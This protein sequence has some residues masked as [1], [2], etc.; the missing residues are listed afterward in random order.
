MRDRQASMLSVGDMPVNRE[1]L[2]AVA[3]AVAAVLVLHRPHATSCCGEI[4]RLPDR[5]AG[6]GRR[7]GRLA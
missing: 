5:H 7:A 3:R 4:S 6:G 1:L 2:E